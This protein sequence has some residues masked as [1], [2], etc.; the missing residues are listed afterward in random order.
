MDECLVVAIKACVSDMIKGVGRSLATRAGAIGV[1]GFP[2][3][4]L[5]NARQIFV[6]NVDWMLH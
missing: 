6:Q 2:A 1:D 3:F 5:Q 4:I